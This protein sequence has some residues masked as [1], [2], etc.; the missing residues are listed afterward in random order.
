M[1]AASPVMVTGEEVPVASDQSVPSFVEN[2]YFEIVA[3]P[4]GAVND[5]LRAV[6]SPATAVAVGEVGADATVV[7][8]NELVAVPPVALEPTARNWR[9]E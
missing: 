5:M 3:E 4:P 6:P 1:F 7:P 8:E 9:V 2:W